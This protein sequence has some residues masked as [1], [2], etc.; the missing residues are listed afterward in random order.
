M[1]FRIAA[2]AP[3]S[4]AVSALSLDSSIVP[5][6]N[7]NRNASRYI[8]EICAVYA[9]VEATAISGPASV[10]IYISAWRAMAEYFTFTTASVF[11]P[12]CLASSMPALVSA[13]SPLWETT[14]TRSPSPTMGSIY[15]NSEATS[16]V[17]GILASPSMA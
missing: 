5:F 12:F 3:R 11:A 10:W 4:C 1:T 15:R 13:V 6:A 7:A 14:I 2:G 9:L 8:T 17:T 16:T